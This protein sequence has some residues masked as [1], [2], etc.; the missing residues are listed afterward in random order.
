MT[1]KDFFSKEHLCSNVSWNYLQTKHF[2][3]INRQTM[4][5]VFFEII[6]LFAKD[7][8]YNLRSCYCMHNILYIGSYYNKQENDF[9]LR[10]N[11]PIHQLTVARVQFIHRRCGN[12]TELYEILKKIQRKYKM[13]NIC[14][15][16]VNT[17]E[18]A[19]WCK[20]N[21]LRKNVDLPLNNWYWK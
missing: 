1:D 10:Y 16:N 14:I 2:K 15:E 9:M 3:S 6:G 7:G 8:N 19:N 4:P 5:S 11:D 13:D 18:M 21:G 12:M 17:D 20:K